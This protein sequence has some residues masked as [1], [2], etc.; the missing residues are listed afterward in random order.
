M[1]KEI[2]HIDPGNKEVRRDRFATH[3]PDI[4][5]RGR[6]ADF[7]INWNEYARKKKF[8]KITIN[9]DTAV[10][11]REHLWSIL[12]MLGSAEEQDALVDP[13][14][15]RT[16]V[17]KFTKMIGITANK[18]IKKG[19]PLNVL[20]EFTLNPETNEVI[21]S[22]GNRYSLLQHNGIPLRKS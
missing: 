14:I 11:D 22:K 5:G 9:G 7:E 16:P 15:K 2:R 20:L 17:T 10:V 4:S 1:S 8:I 6:G 21:I 3:V 13:F 12:F 18:V 19:E